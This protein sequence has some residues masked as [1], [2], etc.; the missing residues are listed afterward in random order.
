MDIKYIII[1]LFTSCLHSRYATRHST[2]SIET[3]KTVDQS[4]E[5]CCN[6]EVGI[7]KIDS[8]STDVMRFSPIKVSTGRF[9]CKS[10]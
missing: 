7:L 3:A 10:K 8:A 9:F 5:N 4:L 1:F 6:T 2:S